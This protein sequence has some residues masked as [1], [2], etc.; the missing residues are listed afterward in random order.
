VSPTS[1]ELYGPKPA[2]PG[3]EDRLYFCGSTS[4]ILSHFCAS[5][6]MRRLGFEKL[7]R[8]PGRGQVSGSSKVGQQAGGF[9][10]L[11]REEARRAAAR[12]RCS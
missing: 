3:L 6:S 12:P 10:C 5:R 8:H 1:R 9:G 2:N 4:L 7:D 11:R